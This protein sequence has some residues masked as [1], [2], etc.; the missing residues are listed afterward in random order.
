MIPYAP[1]LA[2]DLIKQKAKDRLMTFPTYV[3][4]TRVVQWKEGVDTAPPNPPPPPFLLVL[5]LYFPFWFLARR[6]GDVD[7]CLTLV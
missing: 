4:S 7:A 3:G 2:V 6:L 5:S 1:A